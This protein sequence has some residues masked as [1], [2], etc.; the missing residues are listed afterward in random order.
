MNVYTLYHLANQFWVKQSDIHM[1]DASII[2][3][4]M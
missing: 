1:L 3:S 4:F 2:L